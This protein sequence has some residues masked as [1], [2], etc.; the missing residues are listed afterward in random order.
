MSMA[1]VS[2]LLGSTGQF[3]LKLGVTRLGG[4]RWG[5]G[6]FISTIFDVFMEP[7]IV[8][9][10]GLLGISMLIWLAV[11][12]RMQLSTA[13]PLVSLSYVMVTIMSR[14]F[15]GEPLTLSKALGMSLILA[16]ITAISR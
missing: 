2:I 16:G 3:L 11:I 7:F 15:L 6:L 1:L 9:G 12:S 10:V 8:C 5:P 4:V 13:Y 14:L